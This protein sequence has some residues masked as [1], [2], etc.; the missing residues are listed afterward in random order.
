MR[1]DEYTLGDVCTRLGTIEEALG[2]QVN[3]L[4]AI[5]AAVG[6]LAPAPDRALQAALKL[7]GKLRRFEDREV[8]VDR[9]RRAA[10]NMQHCR[11]DTQVEMFATLN[12][13]LVD[14]DSFDKDEP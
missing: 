14:L 4:R 2:A 13:C 10:W 6:A 9:L 1:D 3:A 5:A 12:R 11:F 7:R 8:F